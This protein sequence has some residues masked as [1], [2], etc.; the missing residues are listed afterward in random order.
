LTAD[1]FSAIPAQ[2]KVFITP[3]ESNLGVLSIAKTNAE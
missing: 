2:T 1:L 3:S